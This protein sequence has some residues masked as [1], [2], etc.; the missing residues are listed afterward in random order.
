MSVVRRTAAPKFSAP[1]C[2]FWAE[3]EFALTTEMRRKA[4]SGC[5]WLQESVVNCRGGVFS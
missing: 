1:K 4:V 5:G 3:A 2:L